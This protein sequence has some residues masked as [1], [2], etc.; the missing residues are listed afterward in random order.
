MRRLGVIIRAKTLGAAKIIVAFGIDAKV[1]AQHLAFTAW[2]FD[3][4]VHGVLAIQTARNAGVAHFAHT[5]VG[6]VVRRVFRHLPV[7]IRTRWTSAKLFF[8]AVVIGAVFFR[9]VAVI[10][11]SGACRTVA[12]TRRDVERCQQCERPYQLEILACFHVTS[13]F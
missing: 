12:I 9:S 8:G 5:F 2:F 11:R 3:A 1:S 13:F 10:I 6:D 7:L 4:P